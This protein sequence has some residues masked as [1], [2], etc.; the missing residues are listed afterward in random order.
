MILSDMENYN[1]T[2]V[3][4]NATIILIASI[5]SVFF[6]KKFKTTGLMEKIKICL[7]VFIAIGSIAAVLYSEYLRRFS[8][9]R[10]EVLNFLFIQGAV[11]GL[12]TI[13][14]ILLTFA[15]S[16]NRKLMIVFCLLPVMSLL[17]AVYL[18]YY[19]Y[20]H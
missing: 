1:N 20:N 8:N 9:I 7:G 16:G 3:A 12:F 18:D 17:C 2:M 14:S 4:Y 11:L 6:I 10:D 13:I 15:S 19:H 5:G